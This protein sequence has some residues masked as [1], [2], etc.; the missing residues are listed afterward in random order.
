MVKLSLRRIKIKEVILMIRSF[1][2]R[3]EGKNDRGGRWYP[4]ETEE[5][6]CCKNIRK[7][8]RAYPSSLWKHCTSKA[9]YLNLCE[10]LGEEPVDLPTK[11]KRKPVEEM[12]GY[13]AVYISSLNDNMFSSIYQ[14]IND[15]NFEWKVGEWRKEKVDTKSMYYGENPTSGLWYFGEIVDA[16]MFARKNLDC[17]DYFAIF[18]CRCRYY[19]KVESKRYKSKYICSM[20]KMEQEIYRAR[21]VDT[22]KYSVEELEELIKGGVANG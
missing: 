4:S 7:P 2:S 21:V 10:K 20:L 3:P 22:Y 17:A 19:R 6:S 18:R 15:N 9:H 1:N 16:L 14:V 5:C 8:S 12:I 13:K 11:V